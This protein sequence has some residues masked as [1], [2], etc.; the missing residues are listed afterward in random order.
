MRN[1]KELNRERM[2]VWREKNPER[3]RAL[4]R[5]S[6][7]KYRKRSPG[8]A[9]AVDRDYR[10][11]NPEVR[12][13]WERRNPRYQKDWRRRNPEK[14]RQYH[15]KKAYNFS[16]GEEMIF[17]RDRGNRCEICDGVRLLGVDHNHKTGKVRGL[18][19]R[20]CNSGIGQLKDSIEL[21]VSAVEYLRRT[22]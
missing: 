9:R 20:S 21:L 3:A 6:M 18:L 13:E 15:V 10:E 19:C 16:P 12:K 4:A 17:R 14:L 2:R 1:Q 8:R 22:A 11:R 5:K 7:K